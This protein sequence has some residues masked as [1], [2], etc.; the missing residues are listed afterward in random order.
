MPVH[1][2]VRIPAAD[3]DRLYVLDI[4]SPIL[5]AFFA[6]CRGEDIDR[7]VAANSGNYACIGADAGC[8]DERR[9]GSVPA[10]RAQCVSSL[11]TNCVREWMSSLP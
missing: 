1:K 8:E 9:R 4:A 2:A 6:I 11:L 7:R 5:L 3:P 10:G